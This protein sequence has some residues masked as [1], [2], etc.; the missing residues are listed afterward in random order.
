MPRNANGARP[1]KADLPIKLCSACG[2]P[3]SWRRKW[4][5]DWLQIRYCSKRCR[6]S[7]KSSLKGE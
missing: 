3:F 6:T 1:A 5:K 4:A 7:A 2:R